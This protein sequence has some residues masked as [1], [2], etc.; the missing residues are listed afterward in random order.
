MNSFPLTG[1]PLE[2]GLYDITEMLPDASL[3]PAGQSFLQYG[4]FQCNPRAAPAPE[5][6]AALCTSLPALSA[7]RVGL[8]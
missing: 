7:A 8:H 3:V 6:P 1:I 2:K 4:C 5:G